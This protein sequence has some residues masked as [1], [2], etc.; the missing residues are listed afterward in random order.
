MGGMLNTMIARLWTIMNN[1]WL[2]LLGNGSPH[3][4]LWHGSSWGEVE[5]TEDEEDAGVGD[6]VRGL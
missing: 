5:F 6:N 2:I 4:L 1:K 3:N